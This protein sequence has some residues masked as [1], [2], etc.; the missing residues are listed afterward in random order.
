MKPE[1]ALTAHLRQILGEEDFVRLCQE[2]GGGRVYVPYDPKDESELVLAIGRDAAERLSKEL[3]PSTLRVPLA[4]RDRALYWRGKGLSNR[5]VAR[6]LGI[7][8]T[9]VDK[10]FD[11]EGDLPDRP[12][13]ASNSRQL[14]LALDGEDQ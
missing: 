1:G 7:T 11:R 2:L 5:M 10:L 8:E 9:G 13:K 3:A 4:R 6:K 12:D 14:R